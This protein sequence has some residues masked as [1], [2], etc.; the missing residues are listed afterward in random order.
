[1][2]GGGEGGDVRQLDLTPT[3]AVAAV[4]AVIVIISILLEKVIHKFA[5]VRYSSYVNVVT[6]F[7]Y[8]LWLL[9]DLRDGSCKLWFQVFEE[10]KKHALLEALEK[11]KAGKETQ[12]DTK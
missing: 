2:G 3:W 8:C 9:L 6:L 11:I 7:F 1:M 4:C 12:G 5:K 10:K